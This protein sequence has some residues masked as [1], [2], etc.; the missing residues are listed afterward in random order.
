MIKIV[1]AVLAVV[2]GST[3]YQGDA[4]AQSGN[5]AA[6]CSSAVESGCAGERSIIL[7]R[8]PLRSVLAKRPLRSIVGRGVARRQ[9]RRSQRRAAKASCSG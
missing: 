1:F 8:T 5:C 9:E 4:D 6:S 7:R 3:L 2:V